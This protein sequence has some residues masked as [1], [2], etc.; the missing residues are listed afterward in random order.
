MLQ[1]LAKLTMHGIALPANTTGTELRIFIDGKLAAT[2]PA[3]PQ[4]VAF[5]SVP[6]IG[7]NDAHQ[8]GFCGEI[9]AFHLQSGILPP[10]RLLFQ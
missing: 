2:G 1:N 4:S 10:E 7:A 6:V 8:N 5:N 3:T 9:K